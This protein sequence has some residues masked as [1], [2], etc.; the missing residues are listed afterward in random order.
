MISEENIVSTPHG[1]VVVSVI[2]PTFRR[3]ELLCDAI[4]SVIR[5]TYS[6][7]EIIVI[8]DAGGA[9]QGKAAELLRNPRVIYIENSANKGRSASRNIGLTASSGK[10]ITYL[11]DDDIFYPNHLEILARALTDNNWDVAYTDAYEGVYEKEDSGYRP[12][13]KKVVFGGVFT[14][15]SLW[16]ANTLPIISVMHRRTCLD[17]TG[18]FDQELSILEDWDLWL[19]FSRFYQFH[20]LPEITAE[21]RVRRDNTNT[22]QNTSDDDW[23][24][25]KCLIYLKY[26]KD[27][28]VTADKNL[29]SL[30]RE[31]VSWFLIARIE[32][33]DRMLREPYTDP[34]I[35]ALF[36]YVPLGTWAIIFKK[37][38]CRRFAFKITGWL[39]IH[40]CRNLL[41]SR[42]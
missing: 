8:N 37:K 34:N 40:S 35:I 6:D 12:T 7:W 23:M 38:R 13:T 24:K 29:K 10:Y 39:F 4:E 2:I 26:L 16:Q 18:Y 31:T 32:W 14:L 20:Y 28:L 41:S 5:Q 11:D 25:I 15:G 33:F 27:P 42:H 19:R 3:W 22:T 21:Y 36:H 9:P 17:R 30:L 1:D